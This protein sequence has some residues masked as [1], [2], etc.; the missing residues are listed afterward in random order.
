M[1]KLNIKSIVEL[2]GIQ[3][4]TAFLVKLGFHPSKAS[5]FF[6]TDHSVVKLRD[7]EKLC[8]ALNCTPNDLLEWKPDANT[9][10]PETHALNKLKNEGNSQNLREL[11]KDIPAE[12][13]KL[14]ESLLEELKG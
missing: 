11:I 5:R 6:V 10:L 4:T 7:L 3:K 13:L 9:V 2:R 12:R 14:I 8:I 1:L